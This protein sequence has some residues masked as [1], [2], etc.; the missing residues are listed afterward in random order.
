MDA[1]E[2]PRSPGGLQA[3]GRVKLSQRIVTVPDART[4]GVVTVRV[5]APGSELT[6]PTT[7]TVERTTQAGETFYA[8]KVGDDHGTNERFI[9]AVLVAA[10]HIERQENRP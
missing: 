3:G 2:P 4:P 5:K 8:W 7:G 10:Q 1:A 9:G 6:R